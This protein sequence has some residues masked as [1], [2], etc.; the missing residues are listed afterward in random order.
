MNGAAV[1]LVLAAVS[2]AGRD[3]DPAALR[4]AIDRVLDAPAFANAYWAAEV[5]SLQSGRVLYER[6]ARKNMTPAS[7]MKLLTS[8]GALDAFGPDLRLRT[9]LES[10]GRLDGMGRILGDV[11]LVG[12]GD[13]LLARKGADGRSGF[14]VLADGLRAAGVRRIE[15][16]LIGH[17]GLFRDRR[18]ESWEWSDLVWCYGAEVSALSWNDNCALLR[19]VPGER[20]GDPVAVERWPESAYYSVESRATTSA[21]GSDSDLVLERDLGSAVVRISGSHPQAAEPEELRVALEDPARYAATVFAEALGAR[22]IRVAGPVATSSEPLPAGLRVLAAHDSP[23][24][25]EILKEINKPSQNLYTEMLLRLLGARA[26]GVG[27]VDAGREALAAFLEKLGLGK[28][29]SLQDGSGLSRTDLVTAHDLV[30]LLAAMHRHP[31]G[32]VF[33]ESLAVAGVD[34]TLERRLKG[35]AA[36]GRVFAKTGTLKQT[37]ALA[38]YVRTRGGAWLAFSIVVNHHTATGREATD[39]I[40]AVANLL[41]GR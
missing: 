28:G 23:P 1:V 20:R 32:S 10:A 4:R 7:T 24:L 35:G 17:E 15:G 26:A 40:D 29:A 39:A 3:P 37:N 30:G 34:G 8:A 5:R 25:T 2:A 18:G 13:P 21:A 9:S 27:G 14:D 16:R 38:G 31:H 41:A 33:R 22:G 12:R 36:E 6:N 11:Y 19:V